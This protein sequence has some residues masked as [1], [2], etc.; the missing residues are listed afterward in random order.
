MNALIKIL[1]NTK[2]N[3]WHPIFYFESPLPG[4]GIEDLV[5]YKSN[6][7]HTTGF[8]TR[9]LAVKNINENLINQ[10]KDSTIFTPLLEIEEKTDID[11]NGDNIPADMQVRK[12]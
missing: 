1:H 10:I 3:K 6:G 4:G 7:H 8:D 12:R 11:W 5:R 2:L 9:E